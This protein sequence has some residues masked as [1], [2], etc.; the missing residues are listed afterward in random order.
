M[1][2]PTTPGGTMG[3]PTTPEGRTYAGMGVLVDAL[4]DDALVDALD[5]D[6]AATVLGARG[7]CGY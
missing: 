3:L 5:L 2:L 6:D 4:V 7:R 1:G